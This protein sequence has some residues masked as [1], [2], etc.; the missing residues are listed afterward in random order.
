MSVA[1]S[2][3]HL[4]EVLSWRKSGRSVTLTTHHQLMLKFTN[5]LE[6]CICNKASVNPLLFAYI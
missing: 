6:L 3:R 4:A 5:R 2:L 1:C